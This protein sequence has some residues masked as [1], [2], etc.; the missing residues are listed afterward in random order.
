MTA[1]AGPGGD[2]CS[3]PGCGPAPP[4]SYLCIAGRAGVRGGAGGLGP[5]PPP[6][7]PFTPNHDQEAGHLGLSFLSCGN[8]NG[9][10]KNLLRE[11]G[12]DSARYMP[13]PTAGAVSG[14]SE[15][16]TP[17]GPAEGTPPRGGCIHRP[18]GALSR[19]PGF[20]AVAGLPEW[21]SV[22]PHPQPHRQ[23]ELKHPGG[24]GKRVRGG[25]CSSRSDGPCPCLPEA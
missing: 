12:G 17:D 8:R 18:R 16:G 13:W 4:W 19:S 15:E 22:K 3:S 25:Q 24:A 14:H 23:Q 2:V 20:Q 21:G 6:A 1:V 5:K 7:P 11:D 10:I 9:G